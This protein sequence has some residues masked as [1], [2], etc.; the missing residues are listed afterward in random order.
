MVRYQ[1]AARNIGVEV[2]AIVDRAAPEIKNAASLNLHTTAGASAFGIADHRAFVKGRLHRATDEQHR[3]CIIVGRHRKRIR[4]VRRAQIQ[5]RI[6]LHI[7]AGNTEGI[8]V[9][10]NGQR[11]LAHNSLRRTAGAAYLNIA[12]QPESQL[13][14]GLVQHGNLLKQLRFRGNRNDFCIFRKGRCRKAENQ[15]C[16]YA[17]SRKESL[18]HFIKSFLRILWKIF[19]LFLL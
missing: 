12:A 14:A 3:L 1:H 19:L 8:T 4:A 11:S 6:I 9:A 13:S 2:V 7:Q 17:Q 16:Q 15:D 18:F 10:Q 5:N